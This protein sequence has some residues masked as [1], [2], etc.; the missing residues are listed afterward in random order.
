MADQQDEQ[1]GQ[2]FGGYRLRRRLGGGTFGT[3]YLAAHLQTGSPAA[4]KILRAHLTGIKDF[5][6]FMNE[7]RT[8]RLHHPHIA[9]VLDFGMRKENIPYLVMEYAA[10]G[11]LRQRHPRG[12]R[13]DH[14]T[15]LTYTEQLADALQYAHG[16]RVI[17][18]DLKPE[19]VLV[20]EDGTLL[21]S[22]FGLAKVLEASSPLSQG[23]SLGTPAYM[24]PEQ[25][26]GKPCFASDQY[27]LAVMLYEWITGQRPFQGSV[28]EVALQHRLDSPPTLRS[29][30]PELPCAVE[31]V[32]LKALSKEPMERFSSVA[33]F[34]QAVRE[35]FQAGLEERTVSLPPAC[36]TSL[37]NAPA[38]AS[39]PSPSATLTPAQPSADEA[40]IPAPGSSE[41]ATPLPLPISLQPP[42]GQTAQ[43]GKHNPG[44]LPPLPVSVQLKRHFPTMRTR[45]LICLVLVL[46]VGGSLGTWI[47]AMRAAA[48]TATTTTF[49]NSHTT[50]TTTT[51][52]NGHTTPTAPTLANYH[53]TPTATAPAPTNGHT[54][55]TAPAKP[56]Q[57][58]HAQT[59][60]TSQTLFRIIWSGS[61]Y[62]AVG[63]SGTILTSPNG[64]AWTVQNSSA[65]V[66]LL[67]GAWSGTQFVVVGAQ[68]WS[69]TSPDGRT[70]SL[71]Y[72]YVGDLNGVI[73]SGTQFL[74]VSAG[75]GIFTSSDGHTWIP[76][77]SGTS[78]T[79]YG[80]AW[81][82]TQFV[83]M[84]A[85]GTIL[86][87]PDG[88]TWTTQNSG[89]S[90]TLYGVAWSGSQF[91]VVGSGGTILTSPDG[92]TWSIR[93]S[94]TNGDPFLAVTWGDS[95]FVVVGAGGTIL[96]SPD[97]RTW[98]PRN[99]GTTNEL[100]GV[101][102]SG[103][104]FVVVGAGGT[105]LT[106]P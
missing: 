62:V 68:G 10:G 81:S 47:V 35:A 31:Q 56:S 71:Q 5:K 79:L 75:G 77:N 38:S 30:V 87:S 19:N 72:N 58:W 46:V 57:G 45:V 101:T 49:T 84:G 51:F 63:G 99:S 42:S 36:G 85:G 74:T 61:Q 106:S 37:V 55:P 64:R 66:N 2:T 98:T 50:P 39:S 104:Q 105:I 16:Q 93:Q 18:R 76:Q 43:K 6:R 7:A 65:S 11:T 9:R 91:V 34:A 53:A 8:T 26:F 95:Q 89:T 29:L 22:D 23:T 92:R 12:T 28:L 17:H 70:W 44:T 48:A 82:G 14:L 60:P 100:T 3:V 20:R 73:W 15:I 97:G 52:T 83:V 41:I 24:A 25:G 67:D 4:V 80:V 40:S 69:L 94:S 103:S 102:W 27:A 54:T 33:A 90:Q 32:V 78:Q 59:A 96:T 1:V 88:H 86:T 13:L 21:L